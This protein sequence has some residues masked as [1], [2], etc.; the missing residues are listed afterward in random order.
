MGFEISI[1]VLCA[2]TFSCQ[3]LYWF[4]LVKAIESH[5]SRPER[6]HPLPSLSVI[7]AAKNE[8]ANLN[9]MLPLVLEQDYPDFEVIVVDDHSEDET[10]FVLSRFQERYSH[11]RVCTLSEK[12]HGKKSAISSAVTHAQGKWLG[13]TDA[14]CF[15]ASAVWLR[16]MMEH[17]HTSDVILG[18][19]PYL[20]EP[21]LLNKLIRFDTVLIAIQYFAYA[22]NGVSYM[23]VGRNLFYKKSV[24]QDI[25]GFEKHKDLQSGDDDLFI[26]SIPSDYSIGV[27]IDP[28][29]FTFSKSK[30]KIRDYFR[31]K[32]RH[33]T[34]APRLRNRAKWSL[35]AL[36]FGLII[37]Y[38]CLFLSLFTV[39]FLYNLL[40]YLISISGMLFLLRKAF[41]KFCCS[42]LGP[43][44]PLLHFLLAVFY[45]GLSFT[46]VLPSPRWKN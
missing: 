7:I 21:G 39:Y 24:F 40:F 11:L 25:G 28:E 20:M 27:Q 34:T 30:D 17:S 46:Y 45:L 4:I 33:I 29:S 31:Q 10:S 37:G 32:R 19:G 9:R 14:D 42:D 15:P 43:S 38:I 41:R 44:F 12:E 13:L 3:V 6:S 26:S 16:R 36:N 2:L 22:L 5:S 23:G 8:A 1:L 18:Y 35:F